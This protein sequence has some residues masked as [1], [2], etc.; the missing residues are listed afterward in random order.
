MFSPRHRWPTQRL[1]LV[2][3][4]R[5]FIALAVAV[6][7]RK[8]PQMLGRSA[9]HT[10][11]G[12]GPVFAQDVVAHV[13]VLQLFRIPFIVAHDALQRIHARFLRR[14][15]APHVLHDGVRAA[16]FD[17]LLAVARGPSRANILVGMTASADDRRIA[18]APQ[19]L[20]FSWTLPDLK[21]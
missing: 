6:V 13:H 3:C 9:P 14:H 17:V 12:V 11:S 20:L 10:D 8:A 19:T 1:P 18:R 15:A 2:E 7:Y 5:V 4:D 16:D 21:S